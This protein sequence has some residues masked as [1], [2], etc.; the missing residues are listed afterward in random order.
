M[1]KIQKLKKTPSGKPKKTKW[2]STHPDAPSE[3][4]KSQ[5]RIIT[6]YTDAQIAKLDLVWKLLRN[7]WN[8][9]KD[10]LIQHLKN[11]TIVNTN[12]EAQDVVNF[13]KI[14]KFD[15][16][17]FQ[18]TAKQISNTAP[19]LHLNCQISQKE[20][21]VCGDVLEICD[22]YYLNMITMYGRFTMISMLDSKAAI[23]LVE[24]L[25]NTLQRLGSY[26]WLV[27]YLVFD[28]ESAIVSHKSDC[29]L[30]TSPSPR[31]TERSRMPS[32]A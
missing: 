23:D 28:S 1:S 20:I 12:V 27:K 8:L 25:I 29:L 6:G 31:D 13:F 21:A 19:R 17:K 32:S 5:F 18:G 15:V 4:I 11:N 16:R 30:Y 24:K 2:S 14:F 9:S 3:L 26:G 7:S 10:D 22:V